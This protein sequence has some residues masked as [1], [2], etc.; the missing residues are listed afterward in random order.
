MDE[1]RKWQNAGAMVHFLTRIHWNSHWSSRGEL[2]QWAF[3]KSNDLVIMVACIFFGKLYFQV[4]FGIFWNNKYSYQ[5]L[6]KI[7]LWWWLIR[8]TIGEV[9]KWSRFKI[10]LIYCDTSPHLF[11]CNL[12]WRKSMG[13]R[14]KWGSYGKPRN[15]GV[16]SESP[17]CIDVFC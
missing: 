1:I 15:R 10:K 7:I 4:H 5:K 6:S 12:K 13:K 11:F 8:G 3:W 14:C 16:R 9:K 17:R 2:I